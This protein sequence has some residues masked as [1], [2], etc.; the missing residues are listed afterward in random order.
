MNTNERTIRVFTSRGTNVSITTDVGTW[1][2]LK[3]LVAEH[4]DM[5]NLQ[6]AESVNKTTLEH[7]DARLPETDFIL[8]LRPVKSKAGSE[9]ASDFIKAFFMK[10]EQD[11]QEALRQEAAEH[12]SAFVQETPATRAIKVLEELEE[13]VLAEISQARLDIADIFEI[14][15]E[16]QEES[17]PNISDED[18]DILDDFM[19]GF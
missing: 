19:S 1:G 4:F 15:L 2:E 6:A 9:E 17:R 7:V 13:S 14:E 10:L 11:K 12:E 8:F 5:S 16:D 18:Q 3:P